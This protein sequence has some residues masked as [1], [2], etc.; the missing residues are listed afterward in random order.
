MNLTQKVLTGIRR[1]GLIIP[2]TTVVLG[3]SGGADSVALLHVMH[4]LRHDLSLNLH[5]AHFNHHLRKSASRDQ[6]FVE[7]LASHLNIPVTIGK[8]PGRMIKKLSEAQARQLRFDFLGKTAKKIQASA[9]LLAHHQNDVAETVLM[10]LLR[11]S[12]LNGLRGILPQRVID[13]VNVIRPFLDLNKA[14]IKSFLKASKL[15]FCEDETNQ[16]DDYLRNKV[17]NDLIPKLAKEYNPQITSVLIDMAKTAGDDYDFLHA[18]VLQGFKESVVSKAGKV[19]IKL[20]S[21]KRQHPAMRRLILRHAFAELMGD[22]KQVSFAHIEETEDLIERMAAGA[23]VNWPRSVKAV[24]K[25]DSIVLMKT[26]CVALLVLLFSFSAPL[27]AQDVSDGLVKEAF[28]NGTPK[29]EKNYRNG[30]L[31]GPFR[32]YYPNGN[33]LSVGTYR[34]GQL[35]G[36]LKSYYENGSLFFEKNYFQGQLTGTAREYYPNEVLKSLETYKYDTLD[37]LSQY[38]YPN[39]HLKIAMNFKNG[40]LSGI[41][42]EY[43]EDGMLK[44]EVNYVDDRLEGLSREYSDDG[45]LYA[46][47]NYQMDLKDG[48][49]KTFYS[50]GQVEWEMSFLDGNIDGPNKKYSPDG[51]L[52]IE[53]NYKDNKFNGLVRE[54]HYNGNLKSECNYVT[55][56]KEGLCR[57]YRDDGKIWIEWNYKNDLKEGEAKEYAKDGV[58]WMTVNFANDEKSGTMKEYYENGQLKQEWQMAKGKESGPSKSYYNTGE[59]MTEEAYQDGKLTGVVRLYKKDGNLAY[60]DTYQDG[61]K[62]NR[63]VVDDK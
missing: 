23:V 47:W 43:R 35:H 50:S 27:F 8:R 22:T 10:R 5:I 9:I 13:G 19:K 63:E 61:V 2:G 26:A 36:A 18:H 29:A 21:I 1:Q 60:I 42:R 3:V 32:E 16:T 28:D 30:K 54:F 37:G 15:P 6:K 4:A 41:S 39:G 58:L 51:K 31:N 20:T 62:S 34:D 55:G 14:E 57:E 59:V 52:L 53:A 17:R 45:S 7:A 38:F 12:G 44:N 24:K 46:V 25:K 11:G 48:L 40:K 33:L 49:S 56:K